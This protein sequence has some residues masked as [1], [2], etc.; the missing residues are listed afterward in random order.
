MRLRPASAARTHRRFW[1]TPRGVAY[2]HWRKARLGRRPTR[3]S[4]DPTK[5]GVSCQVLTPS[6]L[7]L[8]ARPRIKTDRRV[9]LPP[10]RVTPSRPGRRT[11]SKGERVGP[12]HACRSAVPTGDRRPADPHRPQ[13]ARRV[14]TPAAGVHVSVACAALPRVPRTVV[15]VVDC[16]LAPRTI[17][18]L[19]RA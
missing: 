4:A 9:S 12:E 11:P 10:A 14:V 7:P 8:P 13:I 2:H 17:R 19:I 3:A 1:S 6:L 5:R 15:E 16:S 18:R